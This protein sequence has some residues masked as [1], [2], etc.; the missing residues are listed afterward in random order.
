M[1]KNVLQLWE[2]ERRRS[3]KKV[4]VANEVK[5]CTCRVNKENLCKRHLVLPQN[6]YLELRDTVW[7]KDSLT[8][9]LI[10]KL[11]EEIK[12][13]PE[14]RPA[15][16][17]SFRLLPSLCVATRTQ[18]SRLARCALIG[19]PSGRSRW[20]QTLRRQKRWHGRVTATLSAGLLKWC[21]TVVVGRRWN[22]GE[23]E[24]VGVEKK[25]I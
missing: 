4:F 24:D 1:G 18:S 17:E 25:Y 15:S 21:R 19:E 5:V 8:K 23:R 9:S 16:A 6:F 20:R 22:K 10:Q 11:Y 3:E 13:V 14:S 2:W 12:D 7:I